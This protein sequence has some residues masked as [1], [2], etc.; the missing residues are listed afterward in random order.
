MM[1]KKKASA[2]RR[3]GNALWDTGT[4][5]AEEECVN[6]EDTRRYGG[7][8]GGKINVS[9]DGEGDY[10]VSLP[11]KK[12]NNKKMDDNNQYNENEFKRCVEEIRARFVGGWL[13]HNE[14]TVKL[15]IKAIKISPPHR[16]IHTLN[17]MLY[18]KG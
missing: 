10:D 18:L 17:Y 6:K 9:G 5:R 7:K 1:D 3:R 14:D 8:T 4:Q 2:S 11:Y 13:Q 12:P 16:C 15:I